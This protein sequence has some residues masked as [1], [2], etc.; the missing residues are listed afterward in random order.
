[1]TTRS[2]RSDGRERRCL[3]DAAVKPEA[4][5]IRFAIGP[6]GQVV[7]DLA[8]H[9]PGRGCW[10]S[11]RADA[12]AEAARKNLFAR[13]AKRGARIEGDLVALVRAALERRLL[14]R[15]G[16][17]RRAGQMVVGFEGVHGGLK[18]QTL[19]WVVEASDSADDGRQKILRLNAAMDDVPV[20]GL[21]DI[22][23]LSAAVGLDNAVHLGLLKG[24]AQKGFAIDLAR[25]SGFCAVMPADWLAEV[26]KTRY[27]S[28]Q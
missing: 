15:L 16:L 12:V 14:D 7:P 19:G 20:L 13:S 27:G 11:A 9:L 17:A 18:A 1:M 5:L 3:V 21:F 24:A 10:V 25:L 6:D 4:D 26:N 22:E 28:V 2:A 23:T 8:A